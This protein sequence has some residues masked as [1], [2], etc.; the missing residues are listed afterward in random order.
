MTRKNLILAAQGISKY[1]E[2]VKI[3][4]N[5]VLYFAIKQ[6]E[7]EAING[8]QHKKK[9]KQKEKRTLKMA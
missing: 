2:A 6:K 3:D 5:T 4:A 7:E 9:Q 8:L 1:L